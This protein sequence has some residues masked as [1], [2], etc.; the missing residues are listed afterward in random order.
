MMKGRL[1]L[2]KVE[3]ILEREK[4]SRAKGLSLVG[5]LVA[6]RLPT[7]PSI[8]GT[9]LERL[10]ESLLRSADLSGWVREFPFT[11]RGR[12]SRVD[13]YFER[14]RLVIEADGR[15][16]HGRFLD[17]EFDRRRDNELTASGIRVLRFTYRML[18]DEPDHCIATVRSLLATPISA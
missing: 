14:C 11:I 6:E 1:D 10:L 17:F 7:A 9:Y 2:S 13:V 15:A 8:D 16:W 5:N 12:P 18:L 3:R 4:E